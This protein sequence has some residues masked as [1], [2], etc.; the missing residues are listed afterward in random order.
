MSPT[1][2]PPQWSGDML[3]RPEI[4]AAFSAQ[5]RRQLAGYAE[6]VAGIRRD[7]EAMWAANPPEGYSTFEAWW[8]ARWV[9]GPLRDIQDHLEQAAAATHALEARYRRGRHEL[10][11]ARQA[12]AAA[13][14]Q[15]ALG[16]ASRRTQTGPAQ[17]PPRSFG[18]GEGGEQGGGDFMNLVKGGR[19]A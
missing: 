19:S 6:F 5:L 4:V 16:Q 11:A 2:V 1:S 13:K 12:A 8:R 17:A 15:P 10:P 7:A 9:R 3:N 18:K 14:N